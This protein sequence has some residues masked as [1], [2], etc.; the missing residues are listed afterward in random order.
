MTPF[1][2]NAMAAC[3]A[4]GIRGLVR[5]ERARRYRVVHPQGRAQLARLDLL[6]LFG[7]R[8]TECLYTGLPTFVSN[9]SDR[10]PHFTVDILGS[11]GVAELERVNTEASLFS[12]SHLLLYFFSLVSHSMLLVSGSS[13]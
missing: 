13:K 10:E 11:N 2:T 8:M 9:A 3:E 6:Q 5:I 7:D 4:A 1:C 12:S